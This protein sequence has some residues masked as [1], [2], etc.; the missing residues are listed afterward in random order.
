MGKRGIESIYG[1]SYWEI[2]IQGVNGKMGVFFVEN[3]GFPWKN[4]GF[5]GKMEVLMG[6]W[7]KNRDFFEKWGFGFWSRNRGK[8]RKSREFD[9]FLKIGEN[10]EK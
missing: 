5:S 4:G 7:W 10:R 9:D 3:P 6:F 1:E 8:V 2:E